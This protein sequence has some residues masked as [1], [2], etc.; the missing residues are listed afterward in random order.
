MIIRDAAEADLPAIVEIYNAAIRGRIS[1]AQLDEVSVEQRLPWFREHSATS[2]PLWMAEIDGEIAGWLSFNP[3]IRRAAYR[4]TAEISVYVGERFR[5]SGVGKALL[6]K[7]IADSP[8]L[9]ITALIGCIFAHNEPSL[10]LFARLG[11]ER[12]GFLPRIALVD[13]I[14]RG[15]VVM[16]RH[17]AR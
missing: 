3:F 5:R 1:T 9:G 16:G 17:V 14:D 7:A 15:V 4:R 12:W 13:G 2:H 6:E 10:Q 11:F 8:D